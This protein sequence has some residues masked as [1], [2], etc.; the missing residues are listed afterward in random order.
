MSSAV[1]LS[2]SNVSVERFRGNQLHDESAYECIVPSWAGGPVQQSTVI[3][4]Q[5]SSLKVLALS[6]LARIEGLER[7]AANNFS[8]DLNL[9]IEVRRFE[10]EL[11]EM[12]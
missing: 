5:I 1:Q 8:E 3:E 9:Q 11:F 2:A 6:L 7:R 12:H 4:S 10:A